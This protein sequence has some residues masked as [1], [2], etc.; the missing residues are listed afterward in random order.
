MAKRHGQTICIVDDDLSLRRSLRNLL[1]SVGF[2]V[3]TFESVEA[4][5]E[6]ANQAEIGCLVLDVR[7]AGMNGL[8]LLKQLGDDLRDVPAIIITGKGSEERAVAAIESGAF[9]SLIHISEP[10]RPY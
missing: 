5:L 4:F 6:S 7:M 3:E 9:L 8:D 10:T 2:R 1:M